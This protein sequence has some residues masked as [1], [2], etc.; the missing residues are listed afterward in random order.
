MDRICATQKQRV[1]NA[2]GVGEPTVVRMC[3]TLG[4]EGCGD[5]KLRIARIL[6]VRLRYL[7]ADTSGQGQG[8][9]A[10]DRGLSA[11]AFRDSYMFQIRAATL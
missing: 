7:E 1:A 8:D 4:C 5:F 10:I 11:V 2:T 6:A 9:S 3:R